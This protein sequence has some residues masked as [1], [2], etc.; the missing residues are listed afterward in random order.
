MDRR[1]IARALFAGFAAPALAFGVPSTT[2]ADTAPSS[3]G[4][5]RTRHG[6]DCFRH[7]GYGYGSYYA[8]SVGHG[9]DRYH[10]GSPHRH[11]M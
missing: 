8:S 4:Y 3:G 10:R 5:P 2:M 1:H 6:H 7:H 9:G 11:G